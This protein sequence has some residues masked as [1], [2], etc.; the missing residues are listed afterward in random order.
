MQTEHD[1]LPCVPRRILVAGTSGS[2]KTTLARRIA[3]MTGLRHT[4][5]D[6]L[7]HGPGWT[8]RESFMVEVA[9][10][11][12][13]PGWVTEWQYGTAR[14][15]LLQRADLLVWLD[16]PP[17][18]VMER[19]VRRTVHRRL[20]RTV[21]WNTNQEL[22]LRTFFTDSDHIV[23]WAWKTRHATARRVADAVTSRPDLTMVRLTSQ[24]AVDAWLAG[25]LLDGCQPQG[26]TERPDGSTEP[27]ESVTEQPDRIPEHPE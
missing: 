10:L 24:Q 19:V 3:A 16:L 22:P 20:G 12:A 4:E 26:I 2:G 18:V 9:A 7:F 11:A 14:P 27:P 1:V 23:R 15:L 21:L 17:S 8:P 6:A 25:P 5:I 13:R